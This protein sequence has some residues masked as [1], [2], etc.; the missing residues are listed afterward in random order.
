MPLKC[1][2]PKQLNLNLW[3]MCANIY[4]THEVVPCVAILEKRQL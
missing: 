1:H 2:M 3:G 4:A